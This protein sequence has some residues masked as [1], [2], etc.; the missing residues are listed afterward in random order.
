[1]LGLG[2]ILGI[3]VHKHQP[4]GY[5]T[6]RSL[7]SRK[8]VET[9]EEAERVWAIGVYEGSSPWSLIEIKRVENPVLTR[10][11]V[12]DV[13]AEL[14]ADPFMIVREGVYYLFF[15]IL[16]QGEDRG[17]IGHAVSADGFEW[18]YRGVVLEEGF[19]LSYPHVFEWNGQVYMVPESNCDF[20]V[21]LYR[22]V[23]FPKRWEFVNK[24][25]TGHDYVDATLFRH[26]DMWWMFVS[27]T[28]NDVLNLYY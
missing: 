19:H 5:R 1:M 27:A 15:E 9:P 16:L 4:S 20:S 28:R 8:K 6:L 17:V 21:R 13:N 22:A 25:L 24:L 3:L 18:Q 14:L 26:D 11:D 7:L 2:G 10:D 12:T 23:E